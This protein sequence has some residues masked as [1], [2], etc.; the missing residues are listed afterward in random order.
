MKYQAEREAVAYFMRRLYEQ[1]LTTTSGGNISQRFNDVILITPS[2]TDKGRISGQEVGILGFDG[3]NHTPELKPSMESN[4]H[5]EIYKARPEVRAIVHAHPV[6]ATS[7][8]ISEREIKTNLAGESWAVIG[9]PVKAGY[10]LMGSLQLANVVAQACLKGNVV[11]L[12]NHGILAVG[13]NLLQAF[14]RVEVTEA[15]AKM[16]FITELLGNRKEL[17][18]DEIKEIDLLFDEK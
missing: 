18:K 3:T 10:R 17:T 12:E 15:A 13:D 5:L 2:Q 11:L 9:K 6:F 8:C 4:M 7:Y 16:T 14:D 1:K